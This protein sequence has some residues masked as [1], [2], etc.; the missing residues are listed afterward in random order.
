[1]EK[2]SL[3]HLNKMILAQALGIGGG[4]LTGGAL[5]ALAGSA[6]KAPEVGMLA[7]SGLGGALGGYFG[8]RIMAGPKK[9]KRD[10]GSQLAALEEKKRSGAWTETDQNNYDYLKSQGL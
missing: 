2:E 10:M 5:G 8:Q 1:M 3:S 9:L 4:A 7:G 6:F